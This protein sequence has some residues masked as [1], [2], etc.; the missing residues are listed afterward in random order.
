MLKKQT[1]PNWNLYKQILNIEVYM[2]YVALAWIDLDKSIAMIFFLLFFNKNA[3]EH[4][5]N[6][7]DIAIYTQRHQLRLIQYR[8][9]A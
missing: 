5:N 6:V 3:L 2:Q 1:V 9:K 8:I 7:T 4:N